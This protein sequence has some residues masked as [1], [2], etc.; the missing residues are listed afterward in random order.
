METE[1]VQSASLFSG[2]LWMIGLGALLF[3]LPVL[4]PLV[5]GYIGGRR[6][7]SV[8]G[9]AIASVLAAAIVTALFM[10]AGSGLGF[11]MLSTLAEA[12]ILIIL[13]LEAVP[14]IGAA[15]VGAATADSTANP[16]A[17][18]E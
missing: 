15:I 9:A 8:G 14:L 1:D 10:V 12:G 4:G 13:L 11:P 5:A 2:T 3:W 16:T 7:G 17:V 18:E 6:S